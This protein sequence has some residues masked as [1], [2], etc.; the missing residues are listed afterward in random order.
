MRVNF[1]GQN[2]QNFVWGSWGTLPL[3]ERIREIVPS[4]LYSTVAVVA[5]RG[6]GGID[7]LSGATADVIEKGVV[8][9]AKETTNNFYMYYNRDL[10]LTPSSD[11]LNYQLSRKLA[12]SLPW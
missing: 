10:K 2:G 4:F 6:G 5:G 9:W 8:V 7:P 12:L 3:C 1:A 11:G